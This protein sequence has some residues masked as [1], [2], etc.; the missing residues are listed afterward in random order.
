MAI[1]AIDERP[2][3]AVV[4]GPP[5]LDDFVD[6]TARKPI[7]PGPIVP[8]SPQI[9]AKF[10]YACG[11]PLSEWVNACPA[12][13]APAAAQLSP[14]NPTEAVYAGFWIRVCAFV[15]D[16]F[17]FWLVIGILTPL[18]RKSPSGFLTGGLGTGILYAIYKIMMESS[19]HQATVGKMLVGIKV[20]DNDGRKIT[21]GRAAVRFFAKFVSW[22]TLCIGFA[23]AGFMPRKRA[24]HDVI[25]ET[26]VVYKNR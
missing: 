4:S 14:T 10:C 1:T 19:D 24:L 3:P 11:K 8:A 15:I 7:A 2:E 12:C 22:I 25:A 6:R 21:S 16:Y 26:L 23:M 20:T 18:L 9:R 17:A 5:L 13:G